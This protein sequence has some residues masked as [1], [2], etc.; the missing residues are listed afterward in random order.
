MANTYIHLDEL[1]TLEEYRGKLDNWKHELYKIFK[2]MNHY[3]NSLEQ[4]QRWYGQSHSEFYED[5]ISMI[6]DKFMQPAAFEFDEAKKILR[7]LEVRASEIGV[8]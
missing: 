2:E 1:R 6:Y 3:H 4:D 5:H 7:Q 8:K